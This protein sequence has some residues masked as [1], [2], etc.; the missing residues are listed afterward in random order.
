M[1]KFLLLFVLGYVFSSC[2]GDG[3]NNNNPYIGNYS[4]SYDVNLSLPA[5]AQLQYVSNAVYI[6][7]IGLGA[8][9]II[10]FNK[11]GDNFAAYDAACPNQ[12][13]TSCS[14]L[15]IRGIEAECPCDME[16]YN[17][18]TGLG[19]MPYP[20]KP[21]RVEKRGNYLRVYN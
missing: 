3:F 16:R 10:I 21:Y 9:G 19:S 5:Y 15:V 1:K 14:T 17:L 20:L 13:L 2:E 4:F 18:F 8:R 6:N 7:Q 11:G 12:P